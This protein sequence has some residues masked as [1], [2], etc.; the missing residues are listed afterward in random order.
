MEKTNKQ[1]VKKYDLCI[2]G[3]GPAGMSASIYAARYKIDQ[4]LIGN[5]PGGLMTSSHK[6][7]NF[8]SR[9]DI[10]GMDLTQKMMDQVSKLDIL[11]KFVTVNDIAREN[12]IFNINLSDGT[13]IKARKILLA[14]GTKH[15]HLDLDR[16]KELTG[17]GVSYCA[18]CDAMFY[19]D[20]IVAVIG[21]SDSANTASLYL[22]QIA[23]KVYQIYRGDKL[24]GETSWIEQVKSNKKITVIYNT[25][26][27][28][29]IGKDK[30]KKIVLDK[31]HDG[32]K[33]LA[34]DGLFVEIGSV[35]D[36]N[37]TEKLSIKT[38]ESGYI[39]TMKDQKTSEKN[40]WAA[41]DITTNSNNFR[42]IITACAEGAIAAED[43]YKT[44]QVEK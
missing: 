13:T 14:T 22:S 31:E 7:C 43:I 6:I 15:R 27:R 8:P 11:Q 1:S 34:I 2:V 44:I 3:N 29:L 41:G 18:T 38:N 40:I 39:A 16:E 24:R 33:E 20:K 36:K 9:P 42:Q 30:L 26:V 5:S 28:K 37:I 25:N 23:K 21:G 4:I 19:K 32:K 12:D 35:P 10:S 17:K